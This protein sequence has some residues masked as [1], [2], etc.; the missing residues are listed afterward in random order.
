[1]SNIL[2]YRGFRARIDFSA[3]DNLFVG[4][5]TGIRDIVTFHASTVEDIHRVMEESVD[6]HIEVSRSVSTLEIEAL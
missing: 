3:D 4:R 5:L 1:M 2:E 6:F